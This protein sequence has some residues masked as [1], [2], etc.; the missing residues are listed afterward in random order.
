[1]PRL[2]GEDG[3]WIVV[4]NALCAIP[5]AEIELT[6]TVTDEGGFTDTAVVTV[7][8][9]RVNRYN[10]SSMSSLSRS[11]THPM[12]YHALPLASTSFFCP[13]FVTRI[14]RTQS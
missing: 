6:A 3:E 2:S 13:R 1:M 9:A 5:A 11:M 8:I 4:A 14:N 7:T 12:A 10:D